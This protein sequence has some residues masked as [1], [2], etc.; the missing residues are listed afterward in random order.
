M[1]NVIERGLRQ[2][3]DHVGDQH[4][5]RQADDE[6]AGADRS[7]RQRQ[8]SRVEL[9]GDRLVAN[10]RS[11]DEL[12]KQRDVQGDIDRIA[13]GLEAPP[14][15]IDDVG[16]AVKGEERDPERKFDFRFPDAVAERDKQG[17]EIGGEEI[18][19]FEHAENQ[20]IA[21]HRAGER[22]FARPSAGAVNQNGGD[23]VE[24]NGKKK[25]RQM[26]GFAPR[27]KYEGERQRNDI[28]ADNC[29]S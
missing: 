13:I 26:P 25:D 1:G 29:R 17:I 4:L 20:Q 6:N 7:V 2:R 3:R 27:I 24:C 16:H 15:Y 14:V 9:T 10:D 23:V 8:P 19:V 21:G 5:L 11:G 28:L 18:G 22:K 12:G